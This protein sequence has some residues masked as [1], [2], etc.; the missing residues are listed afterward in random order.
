MKLLAIYHAPQ[1]CGNPYVMFVNLEDGQPVRTIDIP[2]GYWNSG[3]EA[4]EYYDSTGEII[5]EKHSCNYLPEIGEVKQYR[6]NKYIRLKE[7][8]DVKPWKFLVYE[9]CRRKVGYRFNSSE[10]SFK[11]KLEEQGINMKGWCVYKRRKTPFF[12]FLKNILPNDV[13]NLISIG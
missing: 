8:V 3:F 9:V 6:R 4:E 1:E 2:D 12:E 10:D 11:R 13:V 7:I 5:T